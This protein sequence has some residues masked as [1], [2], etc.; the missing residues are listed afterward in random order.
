MLSVRLIQVPKECIRATVL[1]TSAGAPSAGAALV[2]FV[3]S[4]HFKVVVVGSRG[5][6]AIKR[7]AHPQPSRQ[8]LLFD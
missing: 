5:M 6:G 3:H 2:A 8:C 4:E 7:H 1:P